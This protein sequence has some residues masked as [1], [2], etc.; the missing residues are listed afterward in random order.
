MVETNKNE[1]IKVLTVHGKSKDT[2]EIFFTFFDL[3]EDAHKHC[4]I[5]N[6]IELNNDEWT[7]ARIINDSEKYKL[8]KPSK[9]NFNIFERLCEKDIGGI[10]REI[11][12]D[13]Y[14]FLQALKGANNKI[15]E[16]FFDFDHINPFDDDYKNR[17]HKTIEDFFS[18]LD[19][20]DE[21]PEKVKSAQDYILYIT[22]E[23]EKKGELLYPLV[24]I[25]T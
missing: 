13:G 20:L 5:I 14:S 24:E 23:L 4:K 3:L 11:D 10:V 7:Y 15:R 22:N 17:E 9:Y 18:Y 12:D 6:T 8:K 16:R 2:P 21:S 1:K 25:G 19:S